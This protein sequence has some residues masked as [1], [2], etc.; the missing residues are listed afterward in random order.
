M[1]DRQY[2]NIKPHRKIRSIQTDF[3]LSMRYE[4]CAE[5]SLLLIFSS[6]HRKLSIFAK[7][8]FWRLRQRLP[9][10]LA[11][12]HEN[13]PENAK[14]KDGASGITDW[15]AKF[16]IALPSRNGLSHVNRNR[17]AGRAEKLFWEVLALLN[18]GNPNFRIQGRRYCALP[19]RFKDRCDII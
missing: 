8:S 4:F 19:R 17:D 2:C 11:G 6:D 15:G 16:G 1:P 9:V 14:S 18:E 3:P 5:K 7:Q 13:R 10:L 12:L